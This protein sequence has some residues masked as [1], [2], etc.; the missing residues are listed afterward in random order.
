MEMDAQINIA[1]KSK[2]LS[3][4]DDERDIIQSIEK[5]ASFDGRLRHKV[6]LLMTEHI[7][8]G[9]PISAKK[10]YEYLSDQ[11]LNI[12]EKMARAAWADFILEVR[13][14]KKYTRLLGRFR[15]DGT[16]KATV[17]MVHPRR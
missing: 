12:S 13:H 8:F 15:T 6:W 4:L 7:P 11:G 5:R 17:V 2:H 9:T 1:G 16:A 10:L 14:S 3:V